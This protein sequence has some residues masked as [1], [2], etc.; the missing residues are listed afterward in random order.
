[1]NDPFIWV[2]A[3]HFAAT[4]LVSGIVLFSLFVSEPAFRKARGDGAIAALVRFR[5]ARLAWIGLVFVVISGA[6]W[7]LYVAAR[8]ADLPLSAMVSN[9]AVWTVITRTGFGHD[10]IARLVLA[11]LLAGRLPLRPSGQPIET[12]RR[13]LVA[14]FLGTGLVGTLAWAGHAAAGSGVS[15]TIHLV[16][17]VLHLVVAAAWVGALVPL[18]VLLSAAAR[19]QD[20]PSIAVARD[21][22]LRF[23]TLGVVSVGTLVATGIVNTF[24]LV[25]SAP[26]LVG[27]VYGRLLLLKIALFLVMFVIAGLNR[28]MLTPRLIAAQTG[29]AQGALRQLRS[30]SL[31]EAAIGALIFVSVGVL[32]TWP[33]AIEEFGTM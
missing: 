19:G 13:Q 17:D 20:A 6:A 2:R 27:T 1:M 28:L 11:A 33:P 10:W 14:A 31:I 12:Q 23:S 7:L 25:G 29:A 5:L 24:M 32:G 26:A 30:N 18:A 16:A 15:G 8:M 3:V 21:A 4:M 9:P 22:V